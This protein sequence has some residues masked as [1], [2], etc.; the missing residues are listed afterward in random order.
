MGGRGGEAKAV[1]RLILPI[2]NAQGGQGPGGRELSSYISDYGGPAPAT[3][4]NPLGTPD[5]GKAI[6]TKY[7]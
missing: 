3:L 7:L 2:I 5:I 1:A 4:T 6:E